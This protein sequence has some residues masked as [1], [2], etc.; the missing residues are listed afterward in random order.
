M[1]DVGIYGRIATLELFRP[2]VR[3]AYT[4]A[5]R[6]PNTHRHTPRNGTCARSLEAHVCAHTTPTR[7]LTYQT[8]ATFV[9]YLCPPFAHPL[10]SPGDS[11]QIGMPAQPSRCAF[12][13]QGSDRAVVCVCARACVCVCVCV[14][15]CAWAFAHMRACVRVHGYACIRRAGIGD[16]AIVS[17]DRA[18]Q[19]LRPEIR[20]QHR[21]PR[22]PLQRRHAGTYGAL[23][24]CAGDPIGRQ[25]CDMRHSHGV[26]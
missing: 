4:A 17:V 16:R 22:N 3:V 14:S 6:P 19:V 11:G 26:L 23:P 20:P 21:P 10:V 13:V 2:T 8:L 18:V 24:S 12:G 1:H 15:V 7:T 25:A 5:D 9:H